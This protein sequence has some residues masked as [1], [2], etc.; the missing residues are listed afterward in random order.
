MHDLRDVGG[1]RGGLG[2][3][4]LGLV[5][6]TI[7]GYLLMNQVTVHG[8]YWQWSGWG[9]SRSFG[10]TLIPLLFGVGILF[11]DGR[12]K[13][14]W[15]LATLGAVILF[16]GII[17][18]LDINFRSATLFETIVMLVLLVGGLGLVARSVFPVG[19]S[20]P[21]ASDREP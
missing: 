10:I 6:T 18:N 20:G 13:V 19:N 11:F 15:L 16:A 17:A 1:T 4:V 21:G 14:G 2:T 12:S 9:G 5:M 3:F 8:G 7:G